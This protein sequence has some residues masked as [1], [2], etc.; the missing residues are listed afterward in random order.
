MGYLEVWVVAPK[1]SSTLPLFFGVPGAVFWFQASNNAQLIKLFYD[2]PSCSKAAWLFFFAASKACINSAWL[3]KSVR[4]KPLIVLELFRS[5]CW[6]PWI[7]G[8]EGISSLLFKNTVDPHQGPPQAP[9]T[10]S[11]S[12]RL[13]T[14][15]HLALLQNSLFNNHPSRWSLRHAIGQ[16]VT[17]WIKPLKISCKQFQVMY[18]RVSISPVKVLKRAELAK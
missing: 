10:K 9:V 8:R 14:E 5:E 15:C 3:I 17:L 13:T 2:I 7:N 12:S 4:Y 11:A 6:T 18:M 1:Y 16:L